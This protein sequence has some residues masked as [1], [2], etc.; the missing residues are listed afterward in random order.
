MREEKAVFGE[1][2]SYEPGH[3]TFLADY[4][5]YADGDGMEH[6]NSTVMT[7]PSTIRGDR[8]QLLDTVAH[9]FFHSWNVERIRPRDARAVRLRP[10]E[11]VRR[12]VARRRVHAVLRA[13]AARARR[14]DERRRAATV[15]D[16]TWSTR[17]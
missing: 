8:M 15:P 1:F 14:A 17:S 2:P 16:R 9:E 10:R 12:A 3:Y 6:R 11:H 7:Q 13:A 5:P 4:L